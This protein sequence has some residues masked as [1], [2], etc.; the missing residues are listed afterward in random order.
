MSDIEYNLIQIFIFNEPIC[1]SV[2]RLS[3]I[4]EGIGQSTL[5]TSGLPEDVDNVLINQVACGLLILIYSDVEIK[6]VMILTILLLLHQI[7]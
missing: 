7:W 4:D 5:T 1:I 6:Q 2:Y 3:T